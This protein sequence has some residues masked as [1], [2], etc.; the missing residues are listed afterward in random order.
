MPGPGS[1]QFVN[2]SKAVL[3]SRPAFRGKFNHKLDNAPKALKKRLA[4]LA[5]RQTAFD[6]VLSGKSGYRKPGSM[7]LKKG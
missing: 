7:N 5:R 6:D 1:A 2:K 4:K 3:S